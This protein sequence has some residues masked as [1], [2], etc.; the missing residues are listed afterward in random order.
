MKRNDKRE[1]S[2]VQ[3]KLVRSKS[4]GSLQSSP[5]SIRDLKARFESKAATQKADSSFRSVNYPP[6]YKEADIM[7]VMNGKAE[8]PAEK[9]KPQIP[10]HAPG[11]G[12]KD[13]RVFR[14]VN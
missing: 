11:K 4:M 3:T 13:D 1:R 12:A 6:S 9:T 10:V 8:S 7:Q 14:K 2:R 5:V